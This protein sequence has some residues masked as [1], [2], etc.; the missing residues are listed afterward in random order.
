VIQR[1][2]GIFPPEPSYQKKRYS[3]VAEENFDEAGIH[4]Y[5]EKR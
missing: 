1:K 4:L 5:F 3:V 2:T